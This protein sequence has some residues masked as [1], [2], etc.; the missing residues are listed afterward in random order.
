MRSH[1]GRSYQQAPTAPFH[2]LSEVCGCLSFVRHTT[3]RFCLDPTVE[4]SAALARHAGAARF[5]SN[6]CLRLVKDALTAKQDDPSAKVPWTGF[7]LINTFNGWKKTDAAGRLFVV[8]STGAAEVE[9]TG[10]AWR[11][12]VCQQVFE[13]AAVDL[14]KA[15]VAFTA[16]RNGERAGRRVGFP[17]FKRKGK[18]VESLRLRN[19]HHK[20]GKPSIRVGDGPTP[21]SVTL[22]G[23]G[24]VR[25]HD[26]TRRLRRHIAT[27]R[28]RILFA[29]VSRRAGR[30]FVSLNVEAADLHPADGTSQVPSPAQGMSA[31][32][33]ACT[34]WLWPPRP[35][36]PKPR[37]SPHPSTC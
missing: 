6:T 14:G 23:V 22:P 24:T 30:W 3:F 35:R 11:T 36:A 7:D 27:G 20:G 1:D 21:R 25:V 31:W 18:A 4:Q 34:T 12:E 32:T 13:E 19:K 2:E 17:R 33:E 37:G 15:L 16:S 5:A 9:V 29:T 8:S 10:L 28:G 26:D